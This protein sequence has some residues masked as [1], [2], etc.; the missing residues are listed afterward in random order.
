MKLY[1]RLIASV[2]VLAGLVWFLG[3][4]KHP[5]TPKAKYD[6][7]KAIFRVPNDVYGGRAIATADLDNDGIADLLSTD[8]RGDVYFHKGLGDLKFDEKAY[9]PIFRVPNDVYG[10]RAIA[11]ADLDNDGIADLLS[12]DFRG[13]VYFHKGLGDLKFQ[14]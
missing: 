3:C 7:K 12:T 14:E 4:D 6:N 9:G 5:N 1:Q 2:L 11:T 13:D 8:F 10:G